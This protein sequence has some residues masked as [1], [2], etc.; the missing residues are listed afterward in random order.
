MADRPKSVVAAFFSNLAIAIAKFTAFFFTGSS[1]LLAEGFHSVADTG[2]QALLFLGHRRSQRKASEEHPFGFAPESYFW[3]FV[4]AIVLF[5]LGSLLSFFEGWEKLADPTP[6][7]SPVWAFAVLGI[8]LL[9]ESIG[10]RIAVKKADKAPEMSWFEHIRTTKAG[11]NPVVLLE[12]TAAEAGLMVALVGVTLAVVTGDGRWDAMGSFGIGL[13]LAFVSGLLAVE[14]KSLLIGE[15]ASATDRGEIEAV[16][17]DDPRVEQ[18]L[19]LRTM[20]RGP[21]ELLVNARVEL[22]SGLGLDEVARAISE[23]KSAVRDRLPIARQVVIE[24]GMG[25]GPYPDSR[26]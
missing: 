18:I 17:E 3:A 8:G 20:H 21:E 14:M 26:P 23:L 1:S 13:I 15:A 4:V 6:I 22:S 5:A 7:E 19:V 16:L 24:P 25:E 11:E 10:L 9:T 12:D 2:N